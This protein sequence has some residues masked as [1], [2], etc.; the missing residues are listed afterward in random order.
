LLITF[1]SFVTTVSR[2]RLEQALTKRTY[3]LEYQLT[4]DNQTQALS[5]KAFYYQC[6]KRIAN[7]DTFSL[8]IF[9]VDHFQSVNDRFGRHAGDNAL[10]HIVDIVVDILEKDDRVFRLGGDEFGILCNKRHPVELKQYMEKI[11]AEVELSPWGK[12]P[13]IYLTISLG[14]AIWKRG[15]IEALE[16]SADRAVYKAKASGGNESRVS[17]S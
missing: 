1:I 14:G 3:E 2:Q 16:H 7:N 6:D 11:R 4:H 5:R 10:M 12:N 17:A 9:D 13:P 8:I 15:D